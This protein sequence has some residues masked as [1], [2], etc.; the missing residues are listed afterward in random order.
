MNQQ[1]KFL[2]SSKKLRWVKPK[3]NIPDLLPDSVDQKAME[4]L[5]FYEKDE[6]EFQN[7]WVWKEMGCSPETFFKQ[8][9]N[10]VESLNIPKLQWAEA[11]QKAKQVSR[12]RALEKHK[13]TNTHP[14][15]LMGALRV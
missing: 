6:K 8:V 11:Y 2:T 7:H 10:Y 3:E 15:K 13:L 1:T 5:A 4:V 9:E 12:I 14:F